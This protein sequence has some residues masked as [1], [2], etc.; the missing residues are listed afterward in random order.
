[1]AEIPVSLSSICGGT[2]EEEFQAA[3]QQ[4]VA[5]LKEGQKGSVNIGITLQRMNGTTTIVTASYILS[6]KIPAAKKA[7]VCII[8]SDC[9]LKTEEEPKKPENVIN[10]FDNKEAQ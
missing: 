7:S 3:V 4:V 2:L 8:T 1:M 9:H 6:R 10:L 5:A